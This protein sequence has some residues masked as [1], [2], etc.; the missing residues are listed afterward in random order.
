MVHHYSMEPHA[1]IA[2]VGH[3]QI[4]VWASTQH[5]F[6]VR[7]ELAE[8]F[9]LPLARVQVIVPYLGGATAISPT[10]RLSPSWWR[11]R[12]SWGARCAW[13]LPLRRVLRPYAVLRRAYA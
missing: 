8:M 11:W 7:K 9:G 4:T 2:Q 12:A 13:P 6:P 5:P 10:P 3:D 1:A